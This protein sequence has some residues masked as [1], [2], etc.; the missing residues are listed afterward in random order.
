MPDP[1]PVRTRRMDENEYMRVLKTAFA[2]PMMTEIAAGV[3]E[4]ASA[5]TA[6]ERLDGIDW[7]KWQDDDLFVESVRLQSERL[8]TYHKD[9]L[10]QTFRTAL[11][12][13][14]RGALTEPDIESFMTVWQE[15]NVR[16][17]KTIPERLHNDLLSQMRTTFA[18]RPFDRAALESVLRTEFKSSGYNLR[19][20]TRDQTKK[21]IM[22]LTQARHRQL[23]IVEYR[24]ATQRDERVRPTHAT[25][26]A[27]IYR[28]D[29]PPEDTGHPGNDVQCRCEARPIIPRRFESDPRIVS[30]RR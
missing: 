22:G 30:T 13:D 3:G 9:R 17:V 14:I 15:D 7:A 5:S 1:Q 29:T 27:Q 20:L 6:L 11:S 10:V 4:A 28:W 18:E 12:V 26:D 21:G 19:R 24:W 8:Q 16:L 25:K 23:G 2:D